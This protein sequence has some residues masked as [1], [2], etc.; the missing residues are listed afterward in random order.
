[1]IDGTESLSD[2]LLIFCEYSTF[3]QHDPVFS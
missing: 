1:V 2:D 3:I